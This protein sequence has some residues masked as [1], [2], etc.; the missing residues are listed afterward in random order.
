MKLK[1]TGY[2]GSVH[3][4]V[5]IVSLSVRQTF[6]S[7]ALPHFNKTWH[8]PSVWIVPFQVRLWLQL[9]NAPEFCT[10]EICYAV[11]E[12][13]L[14]VSAKLRIVVISE[15]HSMSDKWHKIFLK[16]FSVM[17]EQNVTFIWRPQYELLKLE[18]PTKWYGEHYIINLYGGYY[19]C[20]S[21]IISFPPVK[22]EGTIG[23]HSVCPSIFL[24][25]SQSVC[26]TR[27]PDFSWLCFRISGW[28]L[29]ASFHLKS[30]RSR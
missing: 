15:S 11:K 1:T 17:I 20:M 3:L 21:L 14:I 19:A 10:F 5:P 8:V 2:I 25:V 29:V 24:S 23:L 7:Q 22:P 28:N 9:T 4:L 16:S 18:V 12:H 30:Y 27:F 26:H 13:D 6:L